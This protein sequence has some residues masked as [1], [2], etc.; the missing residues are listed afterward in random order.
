MIGI[1]VAF[2]VVAGGAYLGMKSG[3]I[4]PGDGS[5]DERKDGE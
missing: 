3:I 5:L 4:E 2:L 1:V